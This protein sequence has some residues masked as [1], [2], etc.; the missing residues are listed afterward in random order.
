MFLTK[1]KATFEYKDEQGIK[2]YSIREPLIYQYKNEFI[3][4]PLNTMTDF[5]TTPRWLRWLFK[6]QN[7]RYSKSAIVHDFLY[8]Q[9][10]TCKFR[11]DFIFLTAMKDEQTEFIKT[12]PKKGW[13]VIETVKC[14]FI[15]WAFYISVSLFGWFYKI[16]YFRSWY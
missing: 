16:G 6:P 11:D 13:K 9:R 15:R 5:A 7:R 3:E 2:W 14:F 10:Q 8:S 12:I 4:V 1:L